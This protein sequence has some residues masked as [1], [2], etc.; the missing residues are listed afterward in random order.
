MVFE[1]QIPISAEG[2][3]QFNLIISQHLFIDPFCSH[4]QLSKSLGKDKRTDKKTK[5]KN[6]YMMGKSLVFSSNA[7][8]FSQIP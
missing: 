1:S 7:K 3:L 2:C 6:K 8:D 4:C 5:M